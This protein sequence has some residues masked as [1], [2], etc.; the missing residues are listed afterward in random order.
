MDVKS[1]PTKPVETEAPPKKSFPIRSKIF[2]FLASLL[3]AILVFYVF[4][5][6]S[7]KTV[8]TVQKN[9]WISLG[10]GLLF[11]V[12]LP[13]GLLVLFIIGFGWKVA[14]SMLF[15]SIALWMFSH[16]LAGI[17]TGYFVFYWI[18]KKERLDWITVCVGVAILYFFQWIPVVGPILSFLLTI[19]LFG[20]FLQVMWKQNHGNRK[21]S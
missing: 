20:A 3:L 21:E 9:F 11:L 4:H 5:S 17:T 7:K 14:L 15:G 2:A 8:E 10:I 19:V 1:A 13:I 12:A 6:S 16:A 18:T